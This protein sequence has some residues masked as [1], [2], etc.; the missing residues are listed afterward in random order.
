MFFKGKQQRPSGFDYKPRFWD[1]KKEE[2]ENRVREAEEFY[3]GKKDENYQVGQK[4]FNFR[5][6]QRVASTSGKQSRFKTDTYGKTNP[7]RLL[8]LIGILVALVWFMLR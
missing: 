3:H 5:Q 6:S 2:F 1:E 8:V 7:I 4:R